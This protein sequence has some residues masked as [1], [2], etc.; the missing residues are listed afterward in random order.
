MLTAVTERDGPLI[1]FNDAYLNF[2][3]P[4]AIVPY[5][6]NVRSPHEKGKVEKGAIH[7]IRYNFLPL[8]SFENLSDLQNQADQ[9]RDHVANIRIHSTTGQRPVDRF[10]TESMRPLPSMLPDCRDTESAKVHS[11]FSVRFDANSY[12]V[13]PWAIGRRVIIKADTHLVSVYLKNKIIAAHKRSYRRRRSRRHGVS[14][15]PG[16]EGFKTT[17]GP[18]WRKSRETHGKP[19]YGVGYPSRDHPG[20]PQRRYPGG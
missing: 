16:P 20:L 3:R 1:S 6:C 18:P 2:L 15:T 17:S 4:F 10:K 13:P 19:A 5:A 11:D 7:Y 14:R 9:W 8:R 12:T